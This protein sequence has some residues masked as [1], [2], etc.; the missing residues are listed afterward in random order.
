MHPRACYACLLNIFSTYGQI[1]EH[2]RQKAKGRGY[3]AHI[4]S[5]ANCL[6]TIIHDSLR[7]VLTTF[8]FAYNLLIRM[9]FS[10]IKRG[11]FL[12]QPQMALHHSI[13]D[14]YCFYWTSILAISLLLEQRT[15]KAY[16]FAKIRLSLPLQRPQ[17]RFLK[18]SLLSFITCFNS[19]TL[20]FAN[21]H[22][23][24][25]AFLTRSS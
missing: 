11:D 24:G 21:S 20:K 12:E 4:N 2:L 17:Y 25:I 22:S 5:P 23:L 3:N 10:P 8:L 16:H 7:L 6:K 18:V 13:G 15:I 1:L 14:I 9:V 19:S